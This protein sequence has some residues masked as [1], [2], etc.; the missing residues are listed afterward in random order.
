MD[1][2][3]SPF[4]RPRRPAAKPEP[5]ADSKKP[6]KKIRVVLDLE[7]DTRRKLKARAA[8]MG[9]DTLRA[10]LLNAITVQG[11]DTSGEPD[12]DV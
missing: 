5:V 8:Q 4:T 12:A 11:V 6:A 7:P 3:T 9:F 10:F 2:K 1:T